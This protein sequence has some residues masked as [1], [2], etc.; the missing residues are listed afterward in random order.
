MVKTTSALGLTT[1][2]LGLPAAGASKVEIEFL[3]S[4]CGE[5]KQGAP[6]VLVAYAS[7][8]GTTGEVADAIAGVLCDKGAACDVR[9]VREVDD[10]ASYDAAVIGSAARMAKW[11]PEAVQLIGKN[12]EALSTKPVAYFVTGTQMVPEQPQL[13][14]KGPP[15][16]DETMEQRQKRVKAY[17][18]PV[19]RKYPEVK[20]VDIGAF[21]GAL[22]FDRLKRAE[23][24]MMKGAG[25]IEGD[26][27]NFERIRAWAGEISP[28]LLKA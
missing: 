12:K 27:R 23:K 4:S 18:D 10:L 26:W 21:A 20:P 14:V 17:L 25:F 9:L 3:R 2:A 13:D 8:C 19:L 24:A 1:A 28:A 11:L 5:D 16:K 7:R 22:Y 6:R 15:P